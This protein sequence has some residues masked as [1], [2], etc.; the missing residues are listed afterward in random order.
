MASGII[1]RRW[2]ALRGLTHEERR[3]LFGSVFALPL[4]ALSI[5]LFG[6][7]RTRSF[8]RR[9]SRDKTREPSPDDLDLA[10][11]LARMVDLAAQHG[12]WPANCLQRSL[13]L[14]RH[15]GRR[16]LPA[17]LRI[18]VRSARAGVE[19]HAWVELWGVVLNDREDIDRHFTPFDGLD[20]S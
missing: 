20:Q 4:I 7:K 14:W 15:L 17:E 8:M 16:A 18:G 3:L 11:R 12:P 1:G 10:R 6:L 9:G 2:D 5:R 19:A 13:V